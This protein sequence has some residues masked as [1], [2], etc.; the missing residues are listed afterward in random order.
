MWYVQDNATA[1]K[2]QLDQQNNVTDDLV[3]KTQVSC[4]FFVKF[5]IGGHSITFQT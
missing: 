2:M 5:C 1:L 4:I 3:S